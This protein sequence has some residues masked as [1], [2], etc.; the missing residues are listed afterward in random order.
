M[1]KKSAEIIEDI[2]EIKFYF[3]LLLCRKNEEEDVKK[4]GISMLNTLNIS[5]S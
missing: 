4:I 5:G 2:K 3:L 1:L